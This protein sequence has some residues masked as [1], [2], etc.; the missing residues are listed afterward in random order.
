[1]GRLIDADLLIERMGFYNTSQ[2][3]EENVG[4]IITLEDFDNMPTA[5]DVDKVV[6]ELE[7]RKALHERLV[8][9]ETKN[10]TVTE[11]YRHIKAI[12]VLNDAIEIVKQGS[13]SDDVC[14]WTKSKDYPFDWFVGCDGCE[15]NHKQGDYCPRCGKKIKVVE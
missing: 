11:K 3:R 4:Q 9:Y 1:M 10:G 14:E 12:D 15:V 6:E 13:V 5:Y 7:E 8:D 2:E